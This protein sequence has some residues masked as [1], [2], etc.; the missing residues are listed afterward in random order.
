MS[1][2]SCGSQLNSQSEKSIGP[3]RIF[4]FFINDLQHKLHLEEVQSLTYGVIF[5]CVNFIT[6]V[7]IEFA[8]VPRR[9]DL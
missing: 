1:V 8:C 4:L 3:Q 9:P 7:K 5:C 2:T 6:V